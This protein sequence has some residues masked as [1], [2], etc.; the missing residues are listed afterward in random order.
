MPGERHHQQFNKLREK[1]PDFTYED[2][3]WQVKDNDLVLCFHFHI[4][5]TFHFHP[6]HTIPLKGYN[7][8]HLSDQ[9]M[10]NMVFH[11]GMVELISY[12]KASCS[13]R[14]SIKPRK[15]NPEQA[16][17]WKRLFFNGLG[18]FFYLNGIDTDV[19]SFMKFSYEKGVRAA[20]DIFTAD[21]T[22]DCIIPVGGGKDSVVT[23]SLLAAMKEKST[24]LVIN[25]R[26]A[27]RA[28]IRVAGLEG[29]VIEVNRTLDP[30]LLELNSK[31]FLNGHTPFSSMLAF[32]SVLASAITRKRHIVLSNEA[33]ANEATIPGTLINHQYSKSFDFEQDFR[34]YVNRFISRDINYFSFLRPLNELQIGALFS[35]NKAYHGVFKSCNVGSKTDTWCCNCSKCLFTWIMLAPFVG[36]EELI[37]IF[38]DDL[39]EKESLKETLDQLSGLASEK[40]FECVG[41]IAEVNSALSHLCTRYAPDQLPLLLKHYHERTQGISFAPAEEELRYWNASHNLKEPFEKLLRDGLTTINFNAG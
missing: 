32:V 13:P 38:G 33:S 6:T 21:F 18:E 31:G 23:L 19:E 36:C 25:Q 10:N 4:N 2:F 11:I 37:K 22:E 7:L 30:L 9:A 29:N 16:K 41:T 40:P 12:W 17:W 35:Q 5:N 8:H 3:A 39:F 27:T 15:L 26:E 1:Y 28:C 14:V 24:A 20:S 34:W